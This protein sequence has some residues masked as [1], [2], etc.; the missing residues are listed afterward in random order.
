MSVRVVASLVVTGTG[1]GCSG[2][3]GGAAGY[4][5]GVVELG[6]DVIGG[7]TSH[8]EQGLWVTDEFVYVAFTCK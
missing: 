1:E 2:C 7:G 4:V 6:Y 3:W 8:T 5:G